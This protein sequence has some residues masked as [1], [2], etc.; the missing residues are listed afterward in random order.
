[1]CV[2][3]HEPNIERLSV[4]PKSFTC[5]NGGHITRTLGVSANLK[6]NFVIGSWFDIMVNKIVSRPSSL[7][8]QFLS[9]SG[10][11]GIGLV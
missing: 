9:P 5:Q 2:C 8:F 4:R 11:L 10:D 3:G 7:V 1:M 6:F